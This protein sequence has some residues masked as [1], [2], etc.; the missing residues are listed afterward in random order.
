MFKLDSLPKNKKWIKRYESEIGG[1]DSIIS[2]G[3]S[4]LNDIDRSRIYFMSNNKGELIGTAKIV[5]YS[6][7]SELMNVFIFKKFRGKGYCSKLLSKT[8]N[9]Y[10]K[11]F[12]K[13]KIH[14]I[15]SKD[16]IPAIKCY[17]S[18][19]FELCTIAFSKRILLNFKKKYPMLIQKHD[20]MVLCL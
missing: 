6:R 17:D 1:W 14:L 8:I 10:R 20:F 5:G 3:I 15:V 2:E 18:V 19:G 12:P 4:S 11:E 9:E 7:G 16:N 13:R